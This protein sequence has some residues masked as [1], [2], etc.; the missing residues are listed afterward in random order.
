MSL[1]FGAKRTKENDALSSNRSFF[2]TL[3]LIFLLSLAGLGE[4]RESGAGELEATWMDNSSNEDGFKIERRTGTTQT[5][6]EIAILGTNVTSYNDSGLVDGETYCYRVLA[7]NAAGSSPY[8]NEECAAARP[9]ARDV[10]LAAVLPSSRSVQVGAVATAFA[11]V[12]NRGHNLATA[13]S[14]APFSGIAASFHYQTTDPNTNQITG[15]ADTPVDIASRGFQSFIIAFIPTQTLAP[16]DSLI[17]FQ[18]TNTDSAPI[19]IGL[20]TLLLSASAIP[21]PDIVALAATAT[22]DGIV[23]IS[24]ATGAGAF[25]VA[26]V[27]V[28]ASGSIIASADTGN[29]ALPVNI[30]LCQTE[31]STGQCIS[32]IGSSV[33]TTINSD[34]TPTFGIFVQSNGNVAF[35]PA[36]NRIFVRFRD[37]GAV[38]RGSTSVAV[39]TQ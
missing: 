5:F 25:A 33:V 36:G 39:R 37:S 6:T 7:F 23:N 19:N 20:N 3:I 11:T 10:L 2:P 32:A 22:N 18:C 31:P 38:T 17:I 4:P 21:V 30:F 9:D 13:C 24:G 14:I 26:T 8:S 15:S 34:A 16:T 35:D 1:V 12:I 29:A 28:G 27:N